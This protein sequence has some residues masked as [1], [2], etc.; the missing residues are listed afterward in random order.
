MRGAPR[1]YEG[2]NR[3]EGDE[4]RAPACVCRGWAGHSHKLNSRQN[5]PVGGHGPPE[6]TPPLAHPQC[7]G[8]RVLPWRGPDYPVL[9]WCGRDLRGVRDLGPRSRGGALHCDSGLEDGPTAR[10]WGTARPGTSHRRRTCCVRRPHGP[11]VRHLRGARDHPL[12]AIMRGWGRSRGRTWGRQRGCRALVRQ[13]VRMETH[14]VR[15]GAR[16]GGPVNSP[17]HT[18]GPCYLARP[19]SGADDRTSSGG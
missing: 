15:R 5:L 2:G 9:P 4:R 1:C 19:S 11:L 17:P 7:R 8:L 10:R 14:R 16:R 18:G 12:P 6:H 3:V 13:R